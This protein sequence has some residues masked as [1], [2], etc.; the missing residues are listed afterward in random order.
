[1]K[2][3]SHEQINT[4]FDILIVGGGPSGMSTW[5]HLHL[6]HSDLASRTLVIDKETFPRDKLCGGGIGGWSGYILKRLDISLTIPNLPISDIEFVSGKKTFLLHQPQC[7]TMVQRIDF[8]HLLV[9]QAKKRGLLFHESE[10]F[11]DFTYDD[12]T[13]LVRTDKQIYRVKVLIG[14]DGALSRVRRSMNLSNKP[15][16]APT[17]EVFSP[18]DD[19][20]DKEYK[21]QRITVDLSYITKG[22]QGY[23]WHVPSINNGKGYIGHGMVDFHII[24]HKPKANMAQIF[25]EVLQSRHISLDK[26]HWRGHPIRWYTPE[27]VI[28][29]PHV[30]LVGDAV[31]IEPAFGGGIHFA[32][33]YGEVAAKMVHDA[34]QA[35]DFHFYDY[36]KRIQ[37]HLI[38]KWIA[39]CTLIAKQLYDNKMDHFEAAREVFTIRPL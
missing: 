39:K 13:I 22:L 14:A 1:M 27:D 24:D 8:D 34:F 21:D 2:S 33:S 18:A 25:N 32:L 23:I 31:G 37:S 6:Y 30:L 19:E 15:H 26:T 36:D 7:F 3:Y 38:G 10:R 4:D 17:L 35:N 11:I 12:N 28:S 16:I 5:L 29:G 9:K 20:V